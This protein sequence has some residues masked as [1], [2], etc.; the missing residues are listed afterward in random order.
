MGQY[1]LRVSLTVLMIPDC[2]Q[3]LNLEDIGDSPNPVA[4]Q[5]ALPAVEL[6]ILDGILF[7]AM[8]QHLGNHSG[9]HLGN[10]Y[11]GYQGRPAFDLASHCMH[12]DC[13]G[14][15]SQFPGNYVEGRRRSPCRSIDVKAEGLLGSGDRQST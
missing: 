6:L 5:I 8:A 11:K 1:L 7:A 2:L 15:A 13:M 10:R 9:I 12:M 4:M 14:C 3:T